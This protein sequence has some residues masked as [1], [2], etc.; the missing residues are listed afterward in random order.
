MKLQ[1]M[2]IRNIL[3]IY[4]T[5]TPA[6]HKIINNTIKKRKGAWKDNAYDV[7]THPD[8]LDNNKYLT[9]DCIKKL[10]TYYIK[11]K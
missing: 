1:L 7:I 8:L 10:N 2:D 4:K 9:D 5:Y 11:L 6:L 3:E